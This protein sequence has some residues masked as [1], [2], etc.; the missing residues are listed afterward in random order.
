MNTTRSQRFA[1][2][3]LPMSAWAWSQAF[4][5]SAQRKLLKHGLVVRDGHTVK[6]GRCTARRHRRSCAF[7]AVEQRLC[8]EHLAELLYTRQELERTMRMEAIRAGRS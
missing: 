3:A 1:L 5:I 6:R 8:R 4:P 7:L 2:R